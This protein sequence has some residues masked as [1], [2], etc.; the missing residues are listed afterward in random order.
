MTGSAVKAAVEPVKDLYTILDHTRSVLMAVED[1]SL[2]SN[3]GG[4]SNVRNILRRTFAILH[5]RGWW[6][7]LGMD[8]FLQ[9]FAQ[10]KK[11]LATIYG[12]FKEYKSFRPIIELEYTRWMTT[13]D[14]Q[15]EKLSKLI[16]K[17]KG[18][19]GVAQLTIDEWILCVTS[20]GISADQVAEV[21]KQEI[22]LNLYYEIAQR[23]EKMVRAAP[24]QLYSTAHLPETNSL[25]YQNHHL[26]EFEGKVLEVMRNVLQN[27]ALNI[28]VLDQSA[29]Y[30]TSGGQEHDVG[31]LV[32]DGKTH[33]VVDVMKVGP[34]VLHVVSPA[35]S[36]DAESYKG[37][38]VQGSI[39]SERR[40]QLRNH[41]T[42]THIVYAS[43]RKVLGPHVWQHGAKKTVDGAHLDIT[44]YQSL[45]HADILAI[46]NEANRIVHRCKPIN[47]SFMAKDEAEKQYGFHLYQGGVV[48]G[49]ELR[50]VNITDTDTEAC[51]G[52]HADNTAEVGQIKIQKGTRISDGILRL[53][54]V[55]GELALQ[56]SN[57]ETDILN[58]LVQ[59][60]GIP[61]DDI[62]P[63]AQRF[64]DGYKK[65]SNLC[66][67]QALTILDLQQKVFLLS[68]SAPLAVYTSNE[69]NATM[70]I[71]NMPP[72]APKLKEKKKGSVY[73]GDS[74]IYGLLGD[75]TL[76]PKLNDLEGFLQK[77][78]EEYVEEQR[79][80][81]EQK[82]KEQDEK[83]AA[84]A[85][86]AAAAAAPKAAAKKQLVRV[87]DTVAITSKDKKGKKV[88][89][90]VTGV[91][92]FAVFAYQGSQE[93][94]VEWFKA[95]GF[96]GMDE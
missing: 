44:H 67:K 40:S 33:D 8:G 29:F 20:W 13:D 49:N 76:F 22:P 1:G 48:P 61:S 81:T 79:K 56:A 85:A 31:K 24:A 87:K 11:D 32:I 78:E 92:E 88:S 64:F 53:Y 27:S 39:D 5:K 86:A 68:D 10:H 73:V 4:A 30:P 34:C 52:T 12:E 80:K 36:G 37:K 58:G 75:A 89:E 25:Y 45:S 65:Y 38:V 91:A 57:Q 18:K 6:Q 70:F 90:K 96:T 7:K 69:P 71:G 35:L 66:S 63:T 59:S 94:V 9:I 83:S 54:F 95:N 74:F 72:F 51:C 16:A 55:A 82:T 15:K 46:E 28:V 62:I 2:P 84:P 3:V 50:V 19:D 14:A 21:T 60:W 42:A 23:Q 43:A 77:L 47:K 93:K 41:H 17:K 26:Y